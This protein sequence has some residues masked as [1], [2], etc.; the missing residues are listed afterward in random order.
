MPLRHVLMRILKGAIVNGTFIF[1][2]TDRLQLKH[3]TIVKLVQGWS[4]I[5]FNP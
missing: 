1:S 2:L 5:A 4:G 3:L